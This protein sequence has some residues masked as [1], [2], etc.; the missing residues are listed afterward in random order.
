VSEG[1]D[2]TQ[3][4]ARNETPVV[5]VMKE[6]AKNGHRENDGSSNQALVTSLPP[7]PIPQTKSDQVQ[8]SL[9]S[10]PAPSINSVPSINPASVPSI[11]PA[12]VLTST[13]LPPA[14]LPQISQSNPAKGHENQVYS[15]VKNSTSIE[16]VKSEHRSERSD[17]KHKDRHRERSKER[18]RSGEKLRDRKER[19]KDKKSKKDRK[20]R[21]DHRDHRDRD[22][23]S[24]KRVSN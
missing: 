23:K 3:N 10:T 9:S 17:R 5:E 12:P 8:T 14:P 20:S 2:L 16:K 4:K 6:Q 22:S 19:H 24:R 11:N 7:V 1:E 13:P 15:D 18:Y 21:R